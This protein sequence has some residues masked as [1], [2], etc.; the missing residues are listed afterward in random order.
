[1]IWICLVCTSHWFLFISKAKISLN[2][3]IFQARSKQRPIYVINLK[4][5]CGLHVWPCTRALSI[6][7]VTLSNSTFH[8][9][10]CLST[11]CCCWRILTTKNCVELHCIFMRV[12]LSGE[13]WQVKILKCEYKW[14]NS[15]PSFPGIIFPALWSWMKRDTGKKNKKNL[16]SWTGQ[17]KKGNAFPSFLPNQCTCMNPR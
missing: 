8:F 3:I 11:D 16:Q 2:L 12:K 9:I 15:T 5:K 4:V 14:L 13:P 6:L 10:Q 7:L 1:M 17:N